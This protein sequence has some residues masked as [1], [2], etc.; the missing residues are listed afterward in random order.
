MEPVRLPLST[1]P[2]KLDCCQNTFRTDPLLE[3]NHAQNVREIQNYTQ[4]DPNAKGT[5]EEFLLTLTTAP[6]KL[7]YV[8]KNVTFQCIK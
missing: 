2:R 7:L 3:T 6:V 1:Q 4:S 8:G 5:M